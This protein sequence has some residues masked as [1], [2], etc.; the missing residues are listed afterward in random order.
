MSQAW[1]FFCGSK[2]EFYINEVGRGWGTRKDEACR[3]VNDDTDC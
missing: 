1:G 3:R 2:S